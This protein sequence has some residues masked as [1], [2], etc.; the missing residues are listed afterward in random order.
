MGAR[1]ISLALNTPDA[2]ALLP[3]AIRAAKKS[4]D[5]KSDIQHPFY[6]IHHRRFISLLA[7]IHKTAK[8]E[9]T[10]TKDHETELHQNQST[11]DG[12]VH[13]IP[14]AKSDQTFYSGFPEIVFEYNHEIL[15]GIVEAACISEMKIRLIGYPKEAVQWSS[16]IPFFAL[17]TRRLL[18]ADKLSLSEYGLKIA[19]SM[20]IHIYEMYHEEKIGPYMDYR[21]QIFAARD[22]FAA[23]YDAKH[24]RIVKYLITRRVRFRAIFKAGGLTQKEWQGISKNIAKH[25]RRCDKKRRESILTACRNYVKESFGE[26]DTFGYFVDAD[27][28][29]VKERFVHWEELV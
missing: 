15:H 28:N 21:S 29:I 19:K 18:S 2:A 14:M 11:K 23:E 4:S 7:A 22:C 17:K 3:A 6:I 20:M 5:A 24:Q 1:A 27:C 26:D 16:H 13:V 10:M 9:L 8:G 25:L 12:D